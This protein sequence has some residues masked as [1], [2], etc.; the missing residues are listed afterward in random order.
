MIVC[1][2]LRRKRGPTSK[3]HIALIILFANNKKSIQT[4]LSDSRKFIGEIMDYV[5]EF[6]GREAAEP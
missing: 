1:D 4:T 3:F 2:V 6:E 5:V